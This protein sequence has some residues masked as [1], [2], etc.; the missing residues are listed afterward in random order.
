M[1]NRRRSHLHRKRKSDRYG[2]TLVELLI[3]LVILA[4][5]AAMALPRLT[6]AFGRTQLQLSAQQ[7]AED[8]SSARLFAI[9][10]GVAYEVE[11]DATGEQYVV[12]PFRMSFDGGAVAQREETTLLGDQK[13][14]QLEARSPV[15]STNQLPPR[16]PDIIE[17]ALEYGVSFASPTFENDED[18]DLSINTDTVLGQRLAKGKSAAEPAISTGTE[19]WEN[20]A[21][22]FSD[23]RADTSSIWLYSTD[24]Y[25]IEIT[26][27]KL[28]GGVKVGPIERQ[29]ALEDD[30]DESGDIGSEGF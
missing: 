24:G 27:R 18:D 30:E 14:V 8:L 23:G 17:A 16:E 2:F 5:F 4:A 11:R 22:F 13:P 7:L 21:R 28:T 20:L 1:Q 10:Q 25:Q 9:E 15:S 3:V 29:P 12:R 19:A 26:V 6:R